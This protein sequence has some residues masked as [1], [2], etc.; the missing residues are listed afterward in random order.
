MSDDPKLSSRLASLRDEQTI[1][2]TQRFFSPRGAGERSSVP[3]LFALV[4]PLAGSIFELS[5]PDVRIGRWRDNEI[6][7]P[8]RQVSKRHCSVRRDSGGRFLLVDHGSTN[9]TRVNDRDVPSNSRT[10]LA[11]GDTIT[12]CDSVMMF[13]N[14]RGSVDVVECKEITVNFAEARKEAQD[15][16]EDF[17]GLDAIRRRARRG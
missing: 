12:I 10:V 14:P 13:V 15:A 9:G 1:G 7:I 4:G 5:V 11:T 2:M 17:P 8:S 6:C 3:H 16:L